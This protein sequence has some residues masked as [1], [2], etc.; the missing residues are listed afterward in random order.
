MVLVVSV[1]HN[2]KLVLIGGGLWLADLLLRLIL[3]L[4]YKK[5]I[6]TATLTNLPGNVIR[7]VFEMEP[8]RSFRYKSGQYVC[9]CIPEI[10]WYEWHPLSISSSPHENEFSL[11]FSAIGNWTRRVQKAIDEKGISIKFKTP[12][13]SY[14]RSAFRQFMHQSS[15]KLSKKD[16]QS[17]YQRQGTTSNKSSRNRQPA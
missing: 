5:N 11:H 7:I 17:K 13:E 10:S 9:I 1:V 6:K 14:I 16:S 15:L 12:Q 2:A 8:D 4:F 3:V